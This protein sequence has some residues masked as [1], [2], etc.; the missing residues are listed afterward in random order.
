M[1][2]DLLQEKRYLFYISVVF[3]K[4]DEFCIQSHL[5]EIFVKQILCGNHNGE[6]IV[7]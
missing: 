7:V 4:N 5:T 3:E 6:M 2:V 1:G